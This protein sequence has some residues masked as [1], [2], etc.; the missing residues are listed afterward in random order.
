MAI[1][2]YRDLQVYQKAYSLSLIVHEMTLKFPKFEQ[3]ELGRQ[4]RK[5]SKSIC[6]NLAEGYGKSKA[7]RA[8]FKR[9]VQ[10]S[11]GSAEEMQVWLSY[12]SD[13]GYIS[14]KKSNE[15]IEAYQEVS[16]ML[17]GLYRSWK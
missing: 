13:L 8:E 3:Q 12:C 7:S 5:A 2:S 10:V 14:D 1:S 6:G 16:R 4:M 15:L 9:Y 11:L 17:Q